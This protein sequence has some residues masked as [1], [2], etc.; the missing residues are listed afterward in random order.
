MEKDNSFLKML[1]ITSI[2][3]C[4]LGIVV[5]LFSLPF[6]ILLW[7]WVAYIVI[8]FTVLQLKRWRDINPYSM[9]SKKKQILIL[10]WAISKV[11]DRQYM[12]CGLCH[13]ISEALD[14]VLNIEPDFFDY[15][16]LYK[17]VPDFTRENCIYLAKKYGFE[18][19]SI[20]NNYW[21]DRSVQGRIARTACLN[22]MIKEIELRIV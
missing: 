14:D 16:N 15:H 4:L 5:L 18:K 11:E 8:N 20:T 19:P 1:L 6:V 13:I 9:I 3:Y 17:Y 12:Y 2:A 10:Q 7:A 21:W 22:A